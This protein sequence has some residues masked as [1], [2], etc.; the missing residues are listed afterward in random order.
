MQKIATATLQ[1]PTYLCVWKLKCEALSGAS[2]TSSS[3]KAWLHLDSMAS[4]WVGSFL[5]L[6]GL[7]Y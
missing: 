3:A 7:L 6:K 5:L 2:A 4:T 1:V